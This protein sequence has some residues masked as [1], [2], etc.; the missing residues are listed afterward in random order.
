MFVICRD[1]TNITTHSRITKRRNDF[2]IYIK[3]IID[4]G[5]FGG[6]YE[7]S[8]GSFEVLYFCL[9]FSNVNSMVTRKL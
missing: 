7:D 9:I 4:I 6:V 3:K 5:L 2:F 1:W 8:I